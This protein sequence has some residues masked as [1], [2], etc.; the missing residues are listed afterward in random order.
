MA[1]G[2]TTVGKR[3]SYKLNMPFIDTDKEIEIKEKMQINQIF[4][5]LGEKDFRKIEEKTILNCILNNNYGFIMSLGGGA[6]INST[7]RNVIQSSGISI[8]LN[9]NIEI[10][11]SRIK[12]TKNTRP[13]LNKIKTREKLISLLKE[14]NS[15]YNKADIKIDII[16]SSKEKMAQITIDNLLNFL[17]SRDA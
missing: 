10:I 17:K 11:E 6:F 13:L 9:A 12:N 14:R 4:S 15:F 1:V 16:R 2:K 3:L 7:I 5:K 8:W